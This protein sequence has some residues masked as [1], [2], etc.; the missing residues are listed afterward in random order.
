MALKVIAK[1]SEKVKA[2]SVSAR[3]APFQLFSLSRCLPTH[4]LHCSTDRKSALV[5]HTFAIKHPATYLKHPTT[6]R[7]LIPPALDPYLQP[8]SP[9]IQTAARF[10]AQFKTSCSPRVIRL[11]P[12]M[13]NMS[14]SAFLTKFSPEISVL[15]Y[16]HVF[17]LSEH[18]TPS[19]KSRPAPT[20][21]HKLQLKAALATTYAPVE[22]SILAA[23]KLIFKEASDVLYDNRTVGG[24][25]DE[26][27][28]LLRNTTFTTL[29]QH[30]QVED[31]ANGYKDAAF[32]PT[33]LSIQQLPRIRSTVILSDG[34]GLTEGD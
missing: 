17:G 12:C 16:G 20:G 23:N 26:L 14:P 18:I 4:T 25:I 33:L 2:G 27:A 8:L 22:T 29:V 11:P 32:I 31:A 6:D 5:R 30:V 7:P 3:T 21:D 24:N 19:T 15:I 1:A 10:S 13:S 28:S 34:F 9:A